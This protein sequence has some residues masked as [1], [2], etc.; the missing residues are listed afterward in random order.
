VVNRLKEMLQSKRGPSI[1]QAYLAWLSPR[2]GEFRVR[3]MSDEGD[4]AA[5]RRRGDRSQPLHSLFT[6]PP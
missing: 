1:F 4:H 6:V 2:G 5:G 3:A